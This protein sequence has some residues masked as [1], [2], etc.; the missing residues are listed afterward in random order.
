[1]ITKNEAEKPNETANEQFQTSTLTSTTSEANKSLPIACI[2]DKIQNPPSNLKDIDLTINN[3]NESAKT[4]GLKTFDSNSRS[5]SSRKSFYEEIQ[6]GTNIKESKQ[7]KIKKED[8][9]QD[10]DDS[11]SSD[12]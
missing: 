2:L 9:F 5:G 8:S 7:E 4:S 10:S 3:P 12:S 11:F 1:M 6:S